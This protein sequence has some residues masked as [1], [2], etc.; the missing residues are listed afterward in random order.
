MIYSHSGDVGSN[1]F[2]RP[3]CVT[4]ELMGR[5]KCYGL[6]LEV[7]IIPPVS[8]NAKILQNFIVDSIYTRALEFNGTCY[9]RTRCPTQAQAHLGQHERYESH[10][11]CSVHRAP[12]LHVERVAFSNFVCSFARFG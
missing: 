3:Y 1:G 5:V 8:G 7:I 10:H 12:S 9:N 6:M 11:P 4:V 2:V